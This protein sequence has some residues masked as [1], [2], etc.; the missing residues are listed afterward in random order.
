[1]DIVDILGKTATHIAIVIVL[2]GLDDK[3][4]TTKGSRQ[5]LARVDELPLG[6]GSRHELLV[7]L[8]D[9]VSHNE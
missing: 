2:R 8:L 4:D 3:L 5:S 7:Q 6:G 1:M 9:G